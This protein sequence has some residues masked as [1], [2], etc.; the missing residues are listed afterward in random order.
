MAKDRLSGKFAVILHADIAGST[1][2]VQQNEHLAHE[3]I[4][5]TFHRFSELINKYQGHVRELRGDALLAEFERPSDAVSAALAFQ[6]RQSIFIEQLDDDILPTTRVGIALGE[7]I[8][9]DNTITGAGV[10]MAQRVEQ[11]SKPGGICITSAIHEALPRRMPYAQEDLGEQS[12][13]GFD[14]QIHVYRV[15]L[16]SGEVIP[17]PEQSRQS[18]P[19][20][21]N[22]KL[23]LA[24]VALALF[25]ASSAY[26]LMQPPKVSGEPASL[27]SILQEIPDKPSIAVL[28]FDNMS[29]DTQQV[30]LSDGI[31][32]DIITDLSK[33][34]NLDVI[35]RN[36]SFSYRGESVNVQ[37]MA[38]EL[39]VG[40]VLEGSVRKAG[41]RIRITAQ[42]INGNTGH[43]VWAERYD[44]RLIDVFELQDEIRLKIVSALSVKLAGNEETQLLRRSTNNFEAYDL[45]LRG[46][47]LFNEYTAESVQQSTELYREAIKLDPEFARALGALGVAMARQKEFMDPDLVDEHLERSLEVVKQAVLI[48]PSSPQVQWALG[49]VYL[50]RGELQMSAKAVEQ[51]VTLSPNFADGWGLLALVNNHLGRGDQALRFIRKGMALNPSYSWDYLYNEGRAYYTMGEYKLA[52]EPLQLAIER[53]ET[54]LHPHLYLGACYLRLGQAD[55][56][57]WEFI[58]AK[59]INPRLSISFLKSVRPWAAGD[60]WDRFFEDMRAGGLSE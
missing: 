43:H 52:V 54:A 39:G 30:Y 1:Q 27:E 57:E 19:F 28:P 21:Q 42:L 55:D 5:D 46:R 59:E 47:R 25:I 38:K 37:E 23:I 18:S 29:D 33:L 12:L 3:R 40:Y 35:A 7:V 4:Q 58:L 11:L 49:F 16:K 53:N 26:Y 31:S 15:A 13:K 48:D 10:V 60:H 36:S 45:F 32:E 22:P 9:S 24:A 20:T 56:A 14:E 6:A 41:N 2:L 34:A 17:Q 8:I 51:S 44:R 50:L